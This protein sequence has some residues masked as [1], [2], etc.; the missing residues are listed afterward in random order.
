MV[1]DLDCEW[2][3][4]GF[5][6]QLITVT[7]TEVGFEHV[8]AHFP[9]RGL[10]MQPESLTV[11]L[12]GC[13]P[14]IGIG[15]HSPPPWC[16]TSHIDAWLLRR[17]NG[18]GCGVSE[19]VS[20]LGDAYLHAF[21]AWCDGL[22]HRL[23]YDLARSLLQLWIAH[24]DAQVHELAVRMPRMHPDWPRLLLEANLLTFFTFWLR[25]FY[26]CHHRGSFECSADLAA[27]PYS[28]L[29][30]PSEESLFCLRLSSLRGSC[31]STLHVTVSPP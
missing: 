8:C 27:F 25:E 12:A 3:S 15:P 28:N 11:F 18:S 7:T 29:A 16:S 21:I 30:S 10:G 13:P 1:S 24:F 19:P 20:D 17:N 6:L 22:E 2:D 5:G 14:L 4:L 9:C 31:C 26:C 23:V